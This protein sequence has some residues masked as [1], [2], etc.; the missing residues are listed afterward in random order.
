MNEYINYVW[1]AKRIDELER[2]VFMIKM[3]IRELRPL[4]L[5]N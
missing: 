5:K 1:L 4:L 3:I 2:E